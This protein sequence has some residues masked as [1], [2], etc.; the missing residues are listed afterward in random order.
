MQACWLSIMVP[1]DHWVSVRMLSGRPRLSP[2]AAAWGSAICCR[3]ALSRHLRLSW[4]VAGARQV[5]KG[6]HVW[7]CGRVDPID[8][9]DRALH[10]VT[11]LYITMGHCCGAQRAQGVPWPFDSSR[12]PWGR[13]PPACAVPHAM[14]LCTKRSCGVEVAEGAR[15]CHC[16]RRR[17]HSRAG[18][19]PPQ[20]PPGQPSS[21]ASRSVQPCLSRSRS[22]R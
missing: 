6:G 2:S 7:Q 15:L 20:A 10:P 8:A 13:P 11:E 9:R 3:A 17:R 22:S 12:R 16:R 5:R 21:R 1:A 4:I 18:S 19:R 14:L